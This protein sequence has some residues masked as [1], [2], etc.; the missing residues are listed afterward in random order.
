MADDPLYSQVGGEGKLAWSAPQPL[1]GSSR[2]GVSETH[3]IDYTPV[4]YVNIPSQATPKDLS[5][6]LADYM[7]MPYRTGAT[8]SAITNRLLAEMDRC[9][10]QLVIIDDAHFMDLSLKEGKVVNDHLKYIANHTAAT[11]IYTGVDLK[12][13]GLF[14]EGTGGSR[15]TQTSGRNALIHMQPFTFATLEDKQDWVSV[16]SAME[17]ALVLYRHKPGSLKRDWKYLRQ[18]TEGNISSLAELIRESAAEAVMTGTEAITRTV[19]NRIEIN[20]HAQT[21]Y[22]STPHQEPEPPATPQQQHPDEDEREAS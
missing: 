21:A 18:R 22:N 11:F 4:V 12:H 7:G 13:S 6:A 16:I 10:V 19:M 14:L 1:D 15:V 3:T 8:K 20:E 17:D 2:R 5:V 9:G